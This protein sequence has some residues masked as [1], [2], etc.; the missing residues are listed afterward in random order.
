MK[1][2]FLFVS[3]RCFATCLLDKNPSNIGLIQINF[4]S[5]VGLQL[6]LHKYQAEIS[7]SCFALF[8]LIALVRDVLST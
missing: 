2:V 8:F 6:A 7:K 4:I 5:D 3:Q 1:W